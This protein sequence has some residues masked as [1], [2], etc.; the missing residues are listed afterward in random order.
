ML[1]MKADRNRTVTPEILYKRT[2]EGEPRLSML[3]E[4]YSK[5]LSEMYRCVC[6]HNGEGNEAVI[7]RLSVIY[8]LSCSELKPAL[9]PICNGVSPLF[10]PQGF[11]CSTE[12]PA[13]P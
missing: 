9:C 3:M 1:H 4:Q 11:L 2:M 6:G 7:H 10:A 5:Q 8:N 13:F 12:I